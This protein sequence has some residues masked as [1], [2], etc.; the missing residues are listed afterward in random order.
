MGYDLD[1]PEPRLVGDCTA[2][3]SCWEVCPGKEVPLRDLDKRFLGRERDPRQDPIGI[4]RKC[5]KA[6][7]TDSFIRSSSSS[8]G[9]TSEILRCALEQDVIDG[10]IIAGWNDGPPYWRCRPLVVTKPEDVRLGVRT[11]MMMVP[12]NAAISEAVLERGLRRVAVVGLP[13]HIHGIR[14]L[15]QGDRPPVFARAI[16]FTIGLFCASAY[17]AEGTRHLLMEVGGIPSLDDVVAID[18]RGGQPPGG[19]VAMT[20][21]RRILHI[22]TKHEYTWHFLAPVSYKR[23]RCLMCV[24]FASELADVSVGDI[25]QDA[26]SPNR[27]V[28]AT[29]ARTPV[30]EEMVD[31]ARQCGKIAVEPHDPHLIPASGT[32]WESKKHAGMYRLIQRKAH[33][34]PVPNYQYPAEIIM[35]PRRLS[36]PS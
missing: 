32:G 16:K 3:G 9:V 1:E 7:A 30:G 11:A 2:C 21:D 25:F 10:A 33:G 24:D 29:I 12:N 28:V 5:L 15:Q 17:Y 19:L 26:N 20:K 14:K 22:A 23:D 36:F 8:G 4:Y 6:W 34:W 13:C 18:Y 27:N 31:L 35:L